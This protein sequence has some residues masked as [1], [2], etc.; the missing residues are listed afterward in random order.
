MY[1]FYT[2]EIRKGHNLGII[3]NTQLQT[4]SYLN[5]PVV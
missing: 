1:R 5:E 2:Q 3:A 4:D